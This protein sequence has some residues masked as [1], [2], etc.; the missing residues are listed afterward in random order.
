MRDDTPGFFLHDDPRN[1]HLVFDLPGYWWSRPHEYAWATTF[2]R[3]GD[4]VLDAACGIS[5]PLKF[6]LLDVCREV[7]ACDNDPRILSGHAILQEI[8]DVF[9]QDAAASFPPRYLEGIRFRQCDI[10]TL[11]YDDQSFDRIFCIS[12][13]EHLKDRFNETAGLMPF[14]RLLRWLLPAAIY[15]TL[16]EFRR[17]L[18]QGGTIVLTFDYPR[19][20]LEYFRRILPLLGLRYAGEGEF[21]VPHNA[22]YSAE[23][24]LYCFH[25]ALERTDSPPSQ[26]G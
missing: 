14:F 7:H 10:S 19:I 1:E 16:K 23:N 25:A 5:H 12:V 2:A 3:T 8:A 13:L 4:V 26:R 22:L 9:G 15:K 18:K 24:K 21:S 6:H 20:N 11:P 17:T